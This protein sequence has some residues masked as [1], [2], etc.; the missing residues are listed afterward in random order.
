MTATEFKKICRRV[1]DMIIGFSNF[2][3]LLNR[4]GYLGE[5]IHSTVM[6]IVIYNLH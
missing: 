4:I 6:S 5:K 1:D 2:A 3:D